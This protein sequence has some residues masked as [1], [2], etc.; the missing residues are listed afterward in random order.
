MRKT[1]VMLGLRRRKGSWITL[2]LCLA[3]SACSGQSMPTQIIDTWVTDD[4]RY[5]GCRLQIAKDRIVFGDSEEGSNDGIVRKVSAAA[6]SNILVVT[7]DYVN[8]ENVPFSVRV[9]YSTGKGGTLWF[10]NQ[11][12]TVWKRLKGQ[13]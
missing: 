10:K 13:T 9:V 1:D 7:I 5:Q 6:E 4:E 3:L 8:L 12:A 2:F 11:P